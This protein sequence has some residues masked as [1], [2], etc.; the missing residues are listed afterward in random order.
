MSILYL[1][2]LHKN[3][4]SA[5]LFSLKDIFLVLN[6][7]AVLNLILDVFFLNMEKHPLRPFEKKKEIHKH[8]RRKQHTCDW[9]PHYCVNFDGVADSKMFK[10]LRPGHRRIL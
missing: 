6:V 5:F 3:C 8:Y 1:L 10:K 2:I 9:L 4:N 7:V